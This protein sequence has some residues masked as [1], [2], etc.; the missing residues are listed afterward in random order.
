[1]QEKFAENVRKISV[2]EKLEGIDGKKENITEGGSIE[3]ERKVKRKGK[4]RKRAD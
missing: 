1:M 4:N 2:V 3:T